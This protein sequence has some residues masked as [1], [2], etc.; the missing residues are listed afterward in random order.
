M[1]AACCVSWLALAAFGACTERDRA[2][3]TA[4]RPI[5]SERSILVPWGS[6]PGEAGLRPTRPDWP[7][8]GPPAIAA[9]A[10]GGILVLDRLNRRVI[11]VS[12]KGTRPVASVPEDAEDL[13]TGPDDTFVVHSLLRSRAWIHRGGERVGEMTIDR[14]LRDLT[15]LSLG[16]SRRLFAHDA[17]Q[18]TVL[19]GSPSVPQPLASVLHSRRRGAFLLAD[20]TGIA[21]RLTGAGRPE[22]LVLAAGERRRVLARH[23]LPE[24]VL[25]A[26]L[27]GVSGDVACLLLEMGTGEGPVN[28]QRTAACHNV[29]TGRRVLE[30]ALGHPGPYLPRRELAVGDSPARLVFA[31]PEEKGL[32]IHEWPL[33]SGGEVA[34]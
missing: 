19:L 31:R 7:G 22:L 26:R 17:F 8:E 5:A 4:S 12:P 10:G 32:R 33:A 6:A 27:V 15:G 13:A 21:V 1:R 34:P 18:Q 3:S 9:P 24:E 11:S 20:G 14:A 16:P 23:T 29:R 25:A 28:V 2:P 30:R